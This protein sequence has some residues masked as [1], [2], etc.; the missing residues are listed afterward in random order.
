MS[1][2][3]SKEILAELKKMN[4]KLDNLNE[5]KGLSSPLKIIAFVVIGPIIALILAGLFQLLR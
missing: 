2:E 1:D 4:E 5:P 3:L